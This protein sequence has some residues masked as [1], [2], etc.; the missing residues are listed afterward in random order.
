MILR[1]LGI[2]RL[3]LTYFSIVL[4]VLLP[5][6]NENAAKA[7]RDAA[8]ANDAVQQF[9]IDAEKAKI[10]TTAEAKVLVSATVKIAESGKAAVAVMRGINA[11]DPAS[12]TKALDAIGIVV[13]QLRELQNTLKI[14]N[15]TTRREVEALLLVVQTGLN[16][17]RLIVASE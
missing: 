12:K 7:L 8:I 14:G 4:L 6:C 3:V 13:D 5:G 15:D 10:L 16:S 1:L 9:A 17:A 2:R 11:Q